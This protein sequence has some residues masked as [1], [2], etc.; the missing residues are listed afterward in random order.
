MTSEKTETEPDIPVVQF[1]ADVLDCKLACRPDEVFVD[2]AAETANEGDSYNG[3]RQV[4]KKE[5]IFLL[6]QLLD[7]APRQIGEYTIH[8][9]DKR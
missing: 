7:D 5:P 3:Q 1:V 2:I 9:A 6:K 4:S 8:A